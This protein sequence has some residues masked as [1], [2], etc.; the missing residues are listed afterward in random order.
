MMLFIP[1]ALPVNEQQ[2]A[3]GLE[4]LLY[5]WGVLADDVV[6]YDT[7]AASISDTNDL[8]LNAF[9][10]KHPITQQFISNQIKVRFGVSRSVRVNPMRSNDESLTV[11]R[12][13]GTNSEHAWGERSYRLSFHYDPG[14]DMPPK[15]LGFAVAS[16]RVTAK[17]KNLQYSVQ[18]GRLVTFSCADF[19]SNNRL[20]N[21]GNL[22]LVLSSINWLVGRDAQLNVAAR[23]I[24]K[25]QL[26]LN[27]Q[28]L[29][30][31]RYSLLFGLP[32]AAALLGL[33]VYW[34][35]RR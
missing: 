25:F 9:D 12:L 8:I 11:T 16:E 14:I 3:T 27:Q 20:G 24:E 22:T 26:T 29:L 18:A 34:T 4:S 19:I 1:P 35:R 10:A 31:L 21:E 2:E 28:E 30:R 33:I 32:G 7:D 17:D 23:P 6:V 15:A 5:D 13:I